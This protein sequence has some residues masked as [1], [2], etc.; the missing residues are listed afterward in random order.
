MLI[1]KPYALVAKLEK[2][3][4]IFA[5]KDINTIGMPI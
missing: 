5:T 3:L 2:L 1:N 4:K